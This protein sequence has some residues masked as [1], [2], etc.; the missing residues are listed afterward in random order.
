M[1]DAGEAVGCLRFRENRHVRHRW[2][3]RPERIGRSLDSNQVV[4]STSIDGFVTSLPCGP[5]VGHG[6]ALQLG[7][8]SQQELAIGQRHG[9]PILVPTAHA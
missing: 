5:S 3:R 2:A 4:S 9:R 8:V 7:L 6:D 1:R